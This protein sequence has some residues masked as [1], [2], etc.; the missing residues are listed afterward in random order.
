MDGDALEG[1]AAGVVVACGDLV[2]R[3]LFPVVQK[4]HEEMGVQAGSRFLDI[5][6]CPAGIPGRTPPGKEPAHERQPAH[7]RRR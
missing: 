7:A 3:E 2:P 6:A 1:K 4:R 5:R